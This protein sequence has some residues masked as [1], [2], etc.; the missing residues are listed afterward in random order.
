MGRRRS[1][2]VAAL[3]RRVRWANV[4]R[5][6]AL[7][8]AGLLIATWPRGAGEGV[9]R[10]RQGEVRVE[11]GAGSRGV[12]ARPAPRRPP[13]APRRGRKAAKRGVGPPGAR[14]GLRPP[15]RRGR[16]P[17]K[18]GV[19]RP[20]APVAPLAAPVAPRATPVAPRATPVAPRAAPVAPPAVPVAPR[21]APRPPPPRSPPASPAPHAPSAPGEFGPEPGA[22]PGRGSPYERTGA[23]PR[24]LALM[25][26]SW[27][28]T[29]S[30]GSRAVTIRFRPCA[31]HERSSADIE[32]AR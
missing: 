8:A 2:G 31:L 11:R 4:G 27:S 13:A 23:S 24:R 21:A 18:K 6:T 12:R 5:L 30:P 7:M 32:R 28:S 17:A 25:S 26:T 9:E 14:V 29:Q 10:P 22:A 1:S 20:A 3:V 19:E 15:R 16:K